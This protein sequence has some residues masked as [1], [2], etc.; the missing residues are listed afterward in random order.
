MVRSNILLS[1][2]LVCEPRMKKQNIRLH[3]HRQSVSGSGMLQ[4]GA[5]HL[6]L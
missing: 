5:A 4:K 6:L 2:I 3:G 1:I